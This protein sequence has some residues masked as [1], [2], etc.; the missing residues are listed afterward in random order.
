VGGGDGSGLLRDRHRRHPR[1]RPSEKELATATYKKG[2]GFYPLM[3]YLDATGEALAGL[4]RQGNAGSGTAEDHIVVSRG[5]P[6]PSCPSTRPPRGHSP[7]RRGGTSHALARRLPGAWCALHRSGHATHRRGGRTIMD[8]PKTAGRTGHIGGRD[9]RARAPARWPRSPTWWTCRGWPEGH[10]HD[11]PSRAAPPRGPAHLHRRRGLSLPGLRHR[12]QATDICF[13][14]ALYRGRG[15]CECRI[16]DTKDTG[17]TNLP[18]ASFAI[19]AA[20]LAV[21]LIASDLLAWMK[22]L[23]L[24]GT[25][26]G[27]A[28]A[29]ALHLC[30]PPG[31]RPFGSTAPRCASPRAGRG[32]TIWSTPSGDCPAGRSSS[33]D[34]SAC[35]PNAPPARLDFRHESIRLNAATE[36]AG[37]ARPHCPPTGTSRPATFGM[38]IEESGLPVTERSGLVNQFLGSPAKPSK[39][40]R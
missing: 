8:V 24:E 25:W 37:S 3:A 1:R 7:D 6:A 17:L 21:V 33:P 29:P 26:P 35:R 22:G 4:L 38:R 34:E 15:R 23:C 2:F 18:S 30:T 14:E 32:P 9:R 19:N 27:R 5:R 28:Q 39:G 11:H 13:M 16:R 40:W 10:P 31:P 12:S 36:G 20:W